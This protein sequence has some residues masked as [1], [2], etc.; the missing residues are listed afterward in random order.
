MQNKCKQASKSQKRTR[1][2]RRRRK[3]KKSEIAS[4]NCFAHRS[5]S[6]SIGDRVDI[7]VCGFHRSV[8]ACMRTR[9]G[10]TLSIRYECMNDCIELDW[11]QKRIH[12]LN[13]S[14]EFW[15]HRVKIASVQCFGSMLERLMRSHMVIFWTIIDP[16][17]VF[18]F[19]NQYF[20][21]LVT[22]WC[23]CVIQSNVRTSG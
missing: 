14:S 9:K 13:H 3:R 23:Q 22:K 2:R 19:W 6:R 16:I 5:T 1:R 21:G 17:R 11:K 20:I 7:C 18:I 8:C 12:T 4:S 10:T 15:I